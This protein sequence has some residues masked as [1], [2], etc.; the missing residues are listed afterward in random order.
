[1]E[2][3]RRADHDDRA[4]RVVDALAEEVLTETAGLA[5][6][7]VGQRL[8]RTVARTGHRTAAAT[9]VEQGVD[10]LLEHALLV[11]DD[12]LGRSEIEQAAQTVVPVDHPAV[13]VVE[14]GRGES[15]ALELHHRAQ[16]GGDDRH[17]VEDHGLRAV[18]ATAVGVATIERRDDLEP[19]DGLLLAL[20]RQGLALEAVLDGVAEDLLLRVEVDRVDEHL[21]RVGSG[22][23]GEVVLITVVDLAPER[24]VLDD[25]AGVEALELVPGT[26]DDLGLVVVALAQ[27][28]EFLLHDLLA[29]LDV[30][31]LRALLLHRLEFCLVVLELPVD[32]LLAL[33]LDRRELLV[34]VGLELGHVLVTLVGV[35]GRDKVGGEVDDLLQLLCLELLLGLQTA[36]E[37]GEPRAGSAQVPDVHDGCGQFDVAHALATHLRARHLDLALLADDPLEAHPLVLPAVALPVA[38]RSEDLLAEESVPLRAKRAVVDGLGLLDL[39]LGPQTD[40]LGRGEADP[41]LVEHVDVEH[42]VL[43]S[44]RLGGGGQLMRAVRRSRSRSSSSEPRSGRL[45]SMPSS[46]AVR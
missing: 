24:L 2:A 40:L 11:V 35:H 20:G 6:E 19:L 37:I 13:E 5:L 41:E 8:Q 32:D 22:A 23:A 7:H 38:G 26:T 36:E 17:D 29:G 45:M 18:D 25:L 10:G 12:D 4:A 30:G 46:S 43:V 34:V 28:G 16:V 9:V 15:S 31:L 1:M 42:R 3:Q 27:R 14:V 21:D 33:L 39:A 44:C